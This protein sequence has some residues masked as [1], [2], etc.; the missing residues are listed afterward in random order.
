[1]LRPLHVGLPQPTPTT[2]WKGFESGGPGLARHAGLQK[3]K[4][5]FERLSEHAWAYTAEGD[6]NTGLVI[7]DDTVLVA[8]IQA[9]PAMAADVSRRICA[10][11]GRPIKHV[12]LTRC[13]AIRRRVTAQPFSG[14]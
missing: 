9:T 12:G 2:R 13:H 7:E 10:V 14:G 5:T 1:M 8:D 4:V 11:T 3:V 6:P